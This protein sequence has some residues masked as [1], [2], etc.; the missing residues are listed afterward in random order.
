MGVGLFDGVLNLMLTSSEENF[1]SKYLQLI[2]SLAM[3][4]LLEGGDLLN[5]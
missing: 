4:S 3:Q 5:Y 2:E 1:C